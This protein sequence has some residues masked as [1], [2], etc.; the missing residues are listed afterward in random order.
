MKWDDK[1]CL[2]VEQIDQQHK[3]L[4]TAVNRI[5]KILEEKDFERNRRACLEAVKYLKSYTLQHFADEE[6]YQR[7]IKYAGYEKHKK[8]HEDF[9]TAVLNSERD[10]EVNNYSIPSIRRFTDLVTN[11][12]INHIMSADQAIVRGTKKSGGKSGFSL[13]R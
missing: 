6:A 8:L 5:N 4:F 7:K 2:G 13:F 1:Y 12:L 10:M 3:G 11:W 9:I